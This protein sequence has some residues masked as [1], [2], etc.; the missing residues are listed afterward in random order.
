MG[1]KRPA[2]APSNP[3]NATEDALDGADRRALAELIRRTHRS[4]HADAAD[5]A[6]AAA[7]AVLAAEWR[8]PAPTLTSEADLA[9]CRPGTVVTDRDGHPWVLNAAGQWCEPLPTGVYPDELVQWAPLT[10]HTDG[11]EPR[12]EP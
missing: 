8:P 4:V 5:A 6:L 3:T 1:A 7:D 9:A 11:P 2:T 10:R 12:A